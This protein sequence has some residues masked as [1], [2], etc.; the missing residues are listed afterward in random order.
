MENVVFLVI[1]DDSTLEGV[2]RSRESAMNYA[3]DMLIAMNVYDSTVTRE[4]I[5]QK[6]N[7]GISFYSIEEYEVFD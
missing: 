3:V 4:E 6:I 1:Y 2:Y 7:N 5:A